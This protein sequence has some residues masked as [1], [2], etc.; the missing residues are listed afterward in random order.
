[1][2]LPTYQFSFEI[3]LQR[4]CRV[5]VEGCIFSQC[6]CLPVKIVPAFSE[7]FLAGLVLTKF[8]VDCGGDLASPFAVVGEVAMAGMMPTVDSSRISHQRT[9]GRQLM[10]QKYIK[11]EKAP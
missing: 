8:F 6:S 5:L 4:Q 2:D 10:V 11:V 1:M 7:W 3:W 9:R